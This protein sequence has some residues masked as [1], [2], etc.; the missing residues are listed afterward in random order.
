[1]VRA[2]LEPLYEFQCNGEIQINKNQKQL[3][4]FLI[5]P[6]SKNQEMHS[7]YKINN[8]LMNTMTL[9][10]VTLSGNNRSFPSSKRKSSSHGNTL[11][12]SFTET[13]FRS[14]VDGES[15]E[16][17]Y[18]DSN[19]HSL[20]N[21]TPQPD[22]IITEHNTKNHPPPDQLITNLDSSYNNDKQT[23]IPLKEI[24]F[25]AI[26][27]LTESD[28]STTEYES[29]SGS[30]L[31][32]TNHKNYAQCRNP[33]TNILHS[34][35]SV[36]DSSHKPYDNVSKTSSNT[37]HPPNFFEKQG[38]KK[39]SMS[40]HIKPTRQ[41][42]LISDSSYKREA[43]S[44][45]ITDD[46]P[47]RNPFNRNERHFS[48]FK[49][50]SRINRSAYSVVDGS[51]KHMEFLKNSKREDFNV[52]IN[53]TSFELFLENY[54]KQLQAQNTQASKTYAPQEKL[55]ELSKFPSVKGTHGG[56]VLKANINLE[57]KVFV[58]DNKEKVEPLQRS[59]ASSENVS[60]FFESDSSL[61][62]EN[63]II[64]TKE[65]RDKTK[66]SKTPCAVKDDILP[67]KSA[68]SVEKSSSQS[69]RGVSLG[70]KNN[71]DY[72]K[73][74]SFLKSKLKK[75]L[76]AESN[77][78]NKTFMNKKVTKTNS[79][80]KLIKDGKSGSNMRQ[81]SKLKVVLLQDKFN[82]TNAERGGTSSIDLKKK[83]F[84][85]PQSRSLSSDAI[86]FFDVN[87]NQNSPKLLHRATNKKNISR[88]TSE[89]ESRKFLKEKLSEIKK[90]PRGDKNT[91]LHHLE[92]LSISS[93][94]S[95]MSHSD[96]VLSCESESVIDSE[97][98]NYRSGMASDED[99]FVFEAV[100][101]VELDTFDDFPSC[102]HPYENFNYNS[103]LKKK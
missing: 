97:Y 67:T 77:D 14:S 59:H 53:Q 39:V 41:L 55:E 37:H 10:D 81:K 87:I 91:F 89:L 93:L 50:L 102:E 83:I 32:C 65:Y 45:F 95:E 33:C 56:E 43:Q 51:H 85:K 64:F 47:F 103:L 90:I 29:N 19:G 57:N 98:D 96:P 1:M 5:R 20:N 27:R 3:T 48:A 21:K 58:N 16:G 75:E 9:K 68:K 17:N 22:V 62:F 71:D 11:L 26:N 82:T 70:A 24:G 6:R 40:Q 42:S 4:Y 79:E 52:I 30:P 18:R 38:D 63:G 8:N 94:N 74:C 69:G 31:N 100:S 72:T 12:E 28:F 54:S 61:D 66:K 2:C 13:S 34:K 99:Y 92:N 46:Q 15:M 76:D 80:E 78:E 44:F 88:L 25:K 60:N 73:L 101:D 7:N 36:D 23:S 49:P 86:A 84:K 35:V